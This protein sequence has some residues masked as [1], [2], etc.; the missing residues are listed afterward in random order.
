MAQASVTKGDVVTIRIGLSDQDNLMGPDPTARRELLRRASDAKLDHVTV[1]DHISFHGG[2]GFDGLI[3]ATSV[4]TA[5]D[6]L[7]VILGVYLLAL[8]HPM[9]AARQL[10]TLCHMAPGRLTMGV[11]VGGEDRSEISNSGVDPA[12][13]GRRLD[14]TLMVLRAL[15]SGEEVTHHGEFFDLEAAS[16]LPPPSP[17]VPIVI[18]GK[19]ETAVRRTARFGDGWLGI[20]CSPRRFARTREQILEAAAEF[21]RQPP[22]WFGVN[23]WCGLD[24]NEADA[25]ELLGQK[26]QSLYQLPYEKFQHIAPAGSPER[27][28]DWL[29]EFTQAGAEHVT[30]VPVAKSVETAIDATAQVGELLRSRAG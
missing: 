2:T 16:I 12:T 8:R 5:Q 15:A 7:S 21:D 19:G 27:V 14:E 10:S 29:T 1:G 11:G 9:L 26:M 17:R 4:L 28:A 22:S 13:R 20:F 18:G 25:R 24:E 6:D 30:L 3:S 23:V